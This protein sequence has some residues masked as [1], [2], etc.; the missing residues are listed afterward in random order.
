MVLNGGSTSAD[1][2]SPM[3]SFSGIYPHLAMFNQH[4][5]C[6]VGAVV[7]WGDKLWCITYAPHCPNG[8]T[9]K[10]YA[11]GAD[12]TRETRPE[13]VGGT[14]AN[15]MIHK[16]SNQLIIGPYFIGA[17]GSVRVIPPVTMP[18]R[19][20]ATAR[21]LSDP[22]RLV[23]FLGME[24][25]LYEVDVHTLA[26]KELYGTHGIPVPGSHAKGGYTGQGRFIFSNNGEWGWKQESEDKGQ[27]GVLAQWDGADWGIVARKQFCEVT[28]PGGINGAHAPDAPI[29]ATGWDNK[30]VI[31]MTLDNDEWATYR[32]PKA[33]Y[34]YDGGHG[35]HTEWP[36]IR[37][38]GDGFLLMDMHGLFYRFP[39]EFRNGQTKGIIPLS[40]HLKMVVDYCKWHD[41][42][43][44]A[45]NDA[46][47]FDNDIV[48][49]AQSNLWFLDTADLSRLGPAAGWGGPWLREDLVA[50]TPSDPFLF[51]GFEQRI[52]HLAHDTSEPV[53]FRIE[54]DSDGAG[55]WQALDSL[56]VPARG[57]VYHIF[58]ESAP[59]VWIRLMPESDA[60]NAAAYFH[61]SQ[62]PSASIMSIAS[63]KSIAPASTPSAVASGIVRPR[64]ENKGT[65]QY[66]AR[67]VNAVGEIEETQYEI[68]GDMRFRRLDDPE[69]QTWFK[70]RYDVNELDYQVDEASVIITENGRR[71]RLPE[72]DPAYDRPFAVGVARGKREIVTERS[73]W[74]CHGTF[75]E[76]PR[77]NSGGVA[78]LKPVCTHNRLITDYCSWR[79]MLVLAG[80]LT[81]AEPDAHFV[82]S[83]DGQAGLWFGTVD[84]LWQL[85]EPTGTGGPWLDTP[86]QANEP[87]EPYLMTGYNRKVIRLNHD[88]AEETIFTVEV[89]FLADDTWHTYDTFAVPAGETLAHVFPDGFSAH[90][91]RVSVSA[92]C[93]ATAQFDY[94]AG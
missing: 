66:I 34:C 62:H 17:E 45:C 43:V 73:L 77:L 23:Y 11:I 51:S 74:N 84:D 20:T 26:A 82:R 15:R 53:T 56:T 21:H 31:L 65:L 49:Q 13:S 60:I 92:P 36:R 16:E 25:E 42:V 90:W 55:Q 64:G 67:T 39:K 48:G 19:H 88:A 81:D 30:S 83:E 3:P 33:S 14:P 10:L 28:G 27:S 24:E 61:Y 41:R 72:G 4:E 22:A 5:E 47:R 79:G 7:P 76:I 29:W 75:Y 58:P 57:Y 71:F 1:A 93:K 8:S 38:L 50:D 78:H 46:S 12:L 70:S 86:V 91:V 54:T 35:W 87:S 44:L 40:S 94:C 69:A 52:L 63:M 9:D 85:G 59:G 80:T 68:D 6:G 32:L 2:E 18:G 37:E 89:D